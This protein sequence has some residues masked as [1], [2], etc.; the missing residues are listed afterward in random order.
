MI[1]RDT[2]GDGRLNPR[3]DQIIGGVIG[4]APPGARGQELRSLDTHGAIDLSRPASAY[5]PKAGKRFGGAI[6]L[7]E[8]T[9]GNLPGLYRPTL[10]LLKDPKHISK[11]EGSSYTY[12]IVV[13]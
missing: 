7:L 4:N 3:T 9:A 2:N 10:V 13:K 12:T 1:L 6:A 11:G 8:F 5:N